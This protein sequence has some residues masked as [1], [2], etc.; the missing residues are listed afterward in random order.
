MNRVILEKALSNLPPNIPP[1]LVVYTD[2]MVTGDPRKIKIA[3][4]IYAKE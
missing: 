3:K 1:R 4:E 2:L